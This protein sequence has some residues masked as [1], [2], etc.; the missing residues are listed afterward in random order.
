MFFDE[1]RKDADSPIVRGA[2]RQKREPRLDDDAPTPLVSIGDL[3]DPLAPDI[4]ALFGV[5]EIG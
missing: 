1:C 2:V 3:Y 4:A 5:D